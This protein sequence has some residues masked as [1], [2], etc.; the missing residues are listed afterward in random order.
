MIVIP[1]AIN[2]LTHVL[3]PSLYL[4][5]VVSQPLSVVLLHCFTHTHTH[6]HACDTYQIG[7]V[8]VGC[9][10]VEGKSRLPPQAPGLHFS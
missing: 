9:L 8:A 10:Q 5:L 7:T 4:S 1:L 3:Y 6:T 2:L